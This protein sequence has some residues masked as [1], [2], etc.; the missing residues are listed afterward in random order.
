[1]CSADPTERFPVLP[2][3]PVLPPRCFC[4]LQRFVPKFDF[5]PR[6]AVLPRRLKRPVPPQG[7]NPFPDLLPHRPPLLL[8]A[9]MAAARAFSDCSFSGSL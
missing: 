7:L 5:L 1:L 3:L 9:V 2:L 4:Q 8:A 6:P